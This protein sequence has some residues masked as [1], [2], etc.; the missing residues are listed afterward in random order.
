M[1]DLL[2]ALA[3]VVPPIVVVVCFALLARPARREVTAVLQADGNP[4]RS[5]PNSPFLHE[6]AAVSPLRR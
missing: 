5:G 6:T 1:A 2:F 4:A 3:L